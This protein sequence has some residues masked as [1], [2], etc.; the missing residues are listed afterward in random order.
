MVGEGEGVGLGELRWWSMV[1]FAIS[2]VR[3]DVML[4]S[5]AKKTLSDGPP[6]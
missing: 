5:P 2:D 6:S 1:R 3:F 4:S